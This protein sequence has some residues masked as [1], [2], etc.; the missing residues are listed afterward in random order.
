MDIKAVENLYVL[1]VQVCVLLLLANWSDL[2]LT[3]ALVI[4]GPV[5]AIRVNFLF[6]RKTN[7]IMVF[8]LATVQQSVLGNFKL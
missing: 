6:L 7:M 1:I 8:L 2:M 5:L 3:A 4:V